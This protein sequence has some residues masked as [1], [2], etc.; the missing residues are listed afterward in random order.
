MD[1][2]TGTEPET[3]ALTLRKL[4][5]DWSQLD[6]LEVNPRR[7]E[8]ERIVAFNRRHPGAAAVDILRTKILQDAG[9]QAWHSLGIVA[10]TAGCGTATVAVNLALSIARYR[11]VRVA[12]IDLNLRQPKIA[13]I[14]GFSGRFTTQDFLRGECLTSDL[15]VRVTDNLALGAS[16]M[17]TE[18][19]AELLHAPATAQA[20]TR[21]QADLGAD[22]VIYCLPPLLAGDDCLG[23]LHLM[24]ATLL[25]VAAEHSAT[26]D[27][28]VAERQ[29]R[30]RTRLLGVVLNKCRY[31][32]G[33]ASN[34]AV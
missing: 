7:L 4:P 3:G 15:V 20:L 1:M 18:Q 29:L 6:R 16:Q 28:D 30:A 24:E 8:R 2:I 14:F 33:T 21:L 17:E 34:F 12:L 26:E 25:V 32:V 10:P 11:N 27:I 22:L 31:D 19:A 23:L 13:R 9:E 5:I